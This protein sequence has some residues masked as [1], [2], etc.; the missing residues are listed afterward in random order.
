MKIAG[1]YDCRKSL[2]PA[3]FLQGQGFLTIAPELF[4]GLYVAAFSPNPEVARAAH[5]KAER[6]LKTRKNK[7]TELKEVYGQIGFVATLALAPIP[8]YGRIYCLSTYKA[9]TSKRLLEEYEDW[10][11]DI[12]YPREVY[13]LIDFGQPYQASYGVLA[14]ARTHHQDYPDFKRLAMDLQKWVPVVESNWSKEA[15]HH[16]FGEF[17]NLNLGL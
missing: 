17:I 8:E 3:P 13:R 12:P 6:C 10:G 5:L 9:S 7:D 4:E 1:T 11:D 2:L 15:E 16:F 14:Y